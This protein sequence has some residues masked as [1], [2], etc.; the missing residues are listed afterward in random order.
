MPEV[1][2]FIVRLSREDLSYMGPEKHIKTWYDDNG[3]DV[4]IIHETRAHAYMRK[5]YLHNLHN[6]RG[7]MKLK[8][9]DPDFIKV[10]VRCLVVRPKWNP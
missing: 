9:G 10:Q 5:S 3:Q 2:G 7:G 4:R 1:I 6:E 8:E